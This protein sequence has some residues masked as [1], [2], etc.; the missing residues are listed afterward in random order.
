MRKSV[1]PA[2]ALVLAA[3]AP[4]HVH[5]RQT[6]AAAA[7]PTT[8]VVEAQKRHKGVVWIKGESAHFIVY[9][10]AKMADA[11]VLIARLERFH[12]L[13]RY[14]AGLNGQPEAAA[15]KLELYYFADSKSLAVVDP[16]N[17]PYAIGLYK[18][19]A[20]G[21]QAYGAD[22]YYRPETKQPL[23]RQPENEGLSYIFEAYAKHFLSVN[24][25]HRTPLWFINGFAHYMATA[26]FDDSQ[27]VVGMAP[28]AYA[29]FLQEV[30]NGLDYNLNYKDILTGTDQK[31]GYTGGDASV[32][33]NEFEA[34]AWILT[35]WVES[36]PQNRGKFAAYLNATAS[37]EAPVAAFEKTFG[38]TPARLDY[39]L[40]SYL[41]GHHVMAM[42]MPFTVPAPAPVTFE[43][44]PA[45][46]EKLL[47]WSS[48]LK[49][50]PSADYGRSLLADIRQEAPKYPES[51]LAQG[52]LARAEILFGDPQK[53]LPYL[54]KHAADAP[55]EFES[56]YLL[57]RADLALASTRQGEARA[58]ALT[59][60]AEAFVKA[61]SLDPS[62][63]ATDYFY[64]RAQV[65]NEDMPDNGALQVAIHAWQLSPEVDDYAIAAGLA[66]A[67]L[68][69]TTDALHILHTVADDPHGRS[70]AALAKS[71][72]DRLTAGASDADIVAALKAEPTSE[73][74][75]AR[76]TL[77][78]HAVFQSLVRAMEDDAMQQAADDALSSGDAQ[79]PGM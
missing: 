29:S 13:L 59:A 8:V 49:A 15:P 79:V 62:S 57:G 42:K 67:H 22:M 16:A 24:D 60:A 53:A 19:C 10:D 26:R 56:Q 55:G 7:P 31:K 37:G 78:N 63:A 28:E 43:T 39:T 14:V 3:T 27:A 58:Q 12:S 30:S 36:N 64:F 35:H 73:S 46:A 70:R 51:D 69:R 1:G 17:P 68:G 2:I 75:L 23:E 11:E 40:W 18:S 76:W 44:L 45:S 52:T 20:D 47:V 54:T 72:I 50:C 4:E 32:L 41:H 25:S 6:T 21:V 77:A 5:A 71:W 65:A 9:S 38:L 66:Y 48:A 61:S 33:S 74:G 34:R